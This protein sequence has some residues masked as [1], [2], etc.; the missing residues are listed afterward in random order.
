MACL[1]VTKRLRV[2]ARLSN[3]FEKLQTLLIKLGSR[4]NAVFYLHPNLIILIRVG[5]GWDGWAYLGVLLG[6]YHF[7][8]AAHKRI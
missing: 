2:A 8:S 6:K 4:V 1:K 7:K 5:R 3:L